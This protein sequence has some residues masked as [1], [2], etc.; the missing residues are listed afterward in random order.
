MKPTVASAALVL[1]ALLLAT[2]PAAAHALGAECRLRGGTVE[3]EAYYD[4]DSPAN[5]AR[6]RILDASGKAVAEGRTDAEGRW[7]FPTPPPGPYAVVVDAGD[8]HLVKLKMTV[9]DPPPGD[10]AGSQDKAVPVSEGR[11]REEFTRVPW[12]RVGLGLLALMAL[13]AVSSAVLGRRRGGRHS[14]SPP[15]P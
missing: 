2:S 14:S 8:G 5:R 9:P 11:S 1:L 10:A 3:V 4:D 6:V 13:A 7:S 15:G 12:G